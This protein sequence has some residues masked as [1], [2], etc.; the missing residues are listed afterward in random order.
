MIINAV[1]VGDGPEDFGGGARVV[2]GQLLGH[3]KAVVIGVVIHG[4][5]GFLC[6][7]VQYADSGDCL[8]STSLRTFCT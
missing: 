7:T 1:V 2:S 5:V 8:Y 3:L 6:E 4:S